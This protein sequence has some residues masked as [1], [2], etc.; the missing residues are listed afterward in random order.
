M[1][2]AMRVKFESFFFQRI[3]KN[4]KSVYG[5]KVKSSYWYFVL[6]SYSDRIQRPVSECQLRTNPYF[7][8]RFISKRKKKMVAIH[9]IWISVRFLGFSRTF[10]WFYFRC[11]LND[12]M[13][14]R[15]RH[16]PQIIIIFTLQF[17][18]VKLKVCSS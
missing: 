6:I 16:L 8:S 10:F 3:G 12:A 11:R 18:M 9:F 14:G 17:S 15:L 2:I 5:E 7:V 1:N 4:R 13:S